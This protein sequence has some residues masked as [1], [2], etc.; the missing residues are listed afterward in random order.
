MYAYKPYTDR[1]VWEA[2]VD[3]CDLNTFLSS[4]AWSEVEADLGRDVHRIGIFDAHD[5]LVGVFLA[6]N[7]KARRGNI[8]ICPH[9]PVL[10]NPTALSDVL[11]SLRDELARLGR[12]GGC[13]C[14]RM[15]PLIFDAPEDRRL[16]A[17]AGFRPAPIH[18]Y[19]ELSWILDIT[20]SED[21]LLQGMKKNTRYG[22]RKAEK[23]GVVV[24][25]STDPAEIDTF[26]KLYTQTAERQG[27]VVY[28]RSLIEAEFKR[29]SAQD[30]ACWYFAEYQGETISTAL[31]VYSAT[32]AFYHHGASSHS[33]GAITPGEA[34]QWAIIRDAKARGCV[35]YDFWGVV[36]DEATD[37]PWYGLSKFKKGFGGYAEHYVHAH[38]LPL[39]MHYWLTWGIETFRRWKRKV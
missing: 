25:S 13:V 27:F 6:V 1:A 37:H 24:R 19:S 32:A 34:L 36:P 15:C 2:F 8:L 39:S 17:G 12:T 38:D 22:V 14:V 4:W 5:E 10:K 33:I 9:G 26:W 3:A 18:V 7:H 23:D 16:F 11:P 31:I 35:R 28:P 20:P 30:R 29:F 21:A